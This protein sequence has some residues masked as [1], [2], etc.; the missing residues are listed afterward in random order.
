LTLPKKIQS[1][2]EK[3]LDPNRLDWHLIQFSFA[4]RKGL[5]GL[6]CLTPKSLVKALSSGWFEGNITKPIGF[7]VIDRAKANISSG[8]QI[9]NNA[10]TFVD[11][12]SLL[13][14]FPKEKHSWVLDSLK[15]KNK[16]FKKSISSS[17]L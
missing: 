1:L 7:T 17:K 8:I 2:L 3:C 14:F 5:Y 15:A 9:I 6:V 4:K 11:K 12:E 10:S 16:A 13:R